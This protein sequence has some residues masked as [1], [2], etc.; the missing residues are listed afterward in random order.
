MCRFVGW[1]ASS[2]HY[3]EITSPI[4]FTV[5]L[6]KSFVP[7]TKP[8]RAETAIILIIHCNNTCNNVCNNTCNNV[9][10]NTCN[11]V[12]DRGDVIIHVIMYVTGVTDHEFG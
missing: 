9:C 7:I 2:L 5:F 12:C 3:T 10:N 8:H 6:I 4:A 11:N 1:S